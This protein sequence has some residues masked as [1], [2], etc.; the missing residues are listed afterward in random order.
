MSRHIPRHERWSKHGPNEY[1]SSGVIVRYE[2][3]AWW[4]LVPYQIRGAQAEGDSTVWEQQQDRI[5]PYKRPRNAM[6]AAEERVLLLQRRQADRV[7]IGG[8]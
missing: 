8:S 4:A 2:K 3:G 6:I 5:G 1:R 7:R